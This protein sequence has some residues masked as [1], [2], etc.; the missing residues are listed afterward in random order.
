MSA[1]PGLAGTLPAS[2]ATNRLLATFSAADRAALGG[3]AQYV[4]L[5]RKTIL[6]DQGA[7]VE[8][9]FFPAPGT[10]ISLAIDLE[11]GSS[12]EVASIGKEGAAGG[13]VSCGTSR[14]FGRALVQI[15]GPA[16]R[17]PLPAL[18]AA[19]ARSSAIRSLFCRY[20]DALLAQV[21]QSV[22]CNAAHPL[23][24]RLC[25]WLLT[26]LDRAGSSDLPL[27]QAML[28]E[29]LGVQRTTVNA[30]IQSLNSEELISTS[31]GRLHVND[32]R[33]LER[34]ACECYARVEE[35]FAQSLPETRPQAVD[36]TA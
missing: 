21:M 30:A 13:I 3:A 33:G 15:G 7:E 4:I 32:R 23:D 20:S 6:W 25:R 9:C 34:R 29:M 2:F 17:I 28:A 26:S 11:D 16:F 24:A 5:K 36:A 8:H 10:M 12:V 35:H 31:R 27:T 18:E 22:A 14:A 19:K 1:E